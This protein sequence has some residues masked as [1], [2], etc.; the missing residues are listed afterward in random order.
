MAVHLIALVNT[1]K[2]KAT[3]RVTRMARYTILNL[4]HYTQKY[5]NNNK[6]V[7]NTKIKIQDKGVLPNILIFPLNSI[8]KSMYSTNNPCYNVAYDN[9]AGKECQSM[10]N[11]DCRHSHCHIFPE[12][13]YARLSHWNTTCHSNHRQTLAYLFHVIS[14]ACKELPDLE[15]NCYTGCTA[16]LMYVF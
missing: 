15:R 3:N 1:K 10:S 5:V 2:T 4:W 11:I 14:N 6:P 13:V 12:S 7:H 9:E 8:E 16:N